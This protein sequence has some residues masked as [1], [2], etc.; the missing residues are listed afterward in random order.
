MHV[1]N[2]DLG[3]S[4]FPQGI[5][6]MLLVP[7]AYGILSCMTCGFCIF[8][9]YTSQIL[10]AV[11]S[12]LLLVPLEMQITAH[13]KPHS[14]VIESNICFI[15]LVPLGPVRNTLCRLLRIQMYQK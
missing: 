7:S 15:V 6:W 10:E 3:Y 4:F 9:F 2:A 12:K 11:G 5:V 14:S 8:R 13:L 1:K